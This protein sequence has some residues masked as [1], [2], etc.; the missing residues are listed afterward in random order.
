[1]MVRLDCV[2]VAGASKGGTTRR[3][4]VATVVVDGLRRSSAAAR[5]T[6]L[7]KRLAQRR[8]MASLK[9]G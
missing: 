5:P 7:P 4:I 9:Y 2:L 6:H 3:R 8:G 1:M